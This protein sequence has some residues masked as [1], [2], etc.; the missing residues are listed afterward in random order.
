MLFRSQYNGMA[1]EARMLYED[2]IKPTVYP[3]NTNLLAHMMGAM[4]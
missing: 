1:H 2:W 3:I 4:R